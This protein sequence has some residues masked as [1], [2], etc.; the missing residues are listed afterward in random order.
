MAAYL[1]IRPRTKSGKYQI[2]RK[3]IGNHSY[4]VA[5]VFTE[6][7]AE[8]I[9]SALNTNKVVIQEVAKAS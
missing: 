7:A 9:V 6:T 8:S 2:V 3:G 5:E 1:Y 4:V